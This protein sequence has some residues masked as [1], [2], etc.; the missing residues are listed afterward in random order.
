MRY[1]FCKNHKQSY[2]SGSCPVSCIFHIYNVGVIAKF[3]F[4]FI[5]YEVKKY[6]EHYANLLLNK[7]MSFSH[8]CRSI[9]LQLFYTLLSTMRNLSSTSTIWTLRALKTGFNVIC[10]AVSTVRA[11]VITVSQYMMEGHRINSRKH[12]LKALLLFVYLNRWNI[13]NVE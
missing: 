3:R 9:I 13:W 11:A 1:F 10:A 12:G 6:P 4:I 7:C 2:R 5:I 8:V